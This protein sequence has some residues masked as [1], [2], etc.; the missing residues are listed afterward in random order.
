MSYPATRLTVPTFLLRAIGHLDAVR[1][2]PTAIALA[3]VF[4]G[5][6][7]AHADDSAT[8]ATNAAAVEKLDRVTVTG[9]NIRR[10]DAETPSPVQVITSEELQKS[11]STSIS[12]VLRGISANNQGTLRCRRSLLPGR[13]N[14]RFLIA[15]APTGP[16]AHR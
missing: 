10:T 16:G 9:S 1:L 5:L 6:S 8:P 4:A 14:L 15:S 7:H 12:E 13:V 11:G 2:T 3:A